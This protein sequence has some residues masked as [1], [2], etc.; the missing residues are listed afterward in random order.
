MYII[1]EGKDGSVAIS[2]LA[3]DVKMEQVEEIVEKF[4]GAHPEGAYPRYS[5]VD[6][7]D[8]PE[9]RTFRDAWVKQGS[10]IVVDKNKGRAIHLDRVRADRNKKLEE[11]DKEQLR[12]INYKDKLQKIEEQKQVLRDLPANYTDWPLELQ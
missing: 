8:A 3:A 6:K 1:Y 7:I 4:R 5:V 12:Y 2:V 10:K 9:D 11:L